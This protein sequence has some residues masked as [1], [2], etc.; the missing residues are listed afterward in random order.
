MASEDWERFRLR[1]LSD[2]ALQEQLRAT[3]DWPEFVARSQE[4]AAACGCQ[5]STGDLERARQ[6]GRRV[7]LERWL[8]EW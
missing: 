4:L 3:R 6:A 2:Q 8:P 5:I 7:W 1:V